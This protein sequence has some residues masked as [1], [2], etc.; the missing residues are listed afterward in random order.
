MSS[1][2]RVRRVG[3]W[4]LALLLLAA[5][6]IAVAPSVLVPVLAGRLSAATGANV[7]VGWMSWNPLA[8]RIV[9]HRIAIA[10]TETAPAVITVQA[11]TV[12]VAL[13]RWLDGERALDALILRRPWVS[14]RRTGPGDFNLASL[15]P[16]LQAAMTAATATTAEDMGPPIPLR[17]GA[18]R[19]VSGSI[20]FHDETTVPVLETSLHL[21]DAT[22]RDLVLATDGSAGLAFHVESRIENEPLTLDVS[23]DT[24]PESSHLTATLVAAEASLARALLYVPLGWQRTSGTLDATV[25]Y[26]RRAEKNVLRHHG[27]KAVLALHDLSLTEP[28]ATEPMLRAALVRVPALAVDFIKQ[29]TDLGSIQVD[30]FQALVVGDAAGVHI[31]LA[32]GSPGTEASSWQTTL[33]SVALGKGTAVLRNIL[34]DSGPE[35]VIPLSGGTIRLPPNEVS[36]SFAGALAGGR[37]TLDGRTRGTASTLSFG[38]E[39]L[40]LTEAPHLFGF[41]LPFAKGR[42]H[43][44]L[45]VQL[46]GTTPILSGTLSSTDT[47][48][49][50]SAEHPE[51]V[52]A[53]QRLELTLAESTLDPFSLHLTDATATW[54]YVMIHR[55]SDGVFPLTLAGTSPSPAAPTSDP[56]WLHLDR[57]TVQGGRVE[58][59]DS[60]LPEPY[61]ID[62]T[63]LVIAADGI[64]LAPLRAQRITLKGALDELSPLEVSGTISP[65]STTLAL[66]VDRLLLPPLNPYLAPALGYEVKTGLARI[67]SD[68]RFNGTTLAADND[69]VLSRFAMRRAGQDTV[70]ATI[71][72]P[73]SVALALM[74]DTR[75][76]IHL[77]LPIEGDLTANQYRV[78]NLLREALGN[79]LL[80]TLRAP[81]GFLRGLFSTDQGEQFDLRPV[82]FPAGSATL[83]P[84]GESRIAE[85]AHLLGR[86]T[87]LRAVLIPEPSRADL[88][89][90][91]TTENPRPLDALADLA[92]TR[93]TLVAERLTKGQGIAAAR[94]SIEAWQPAEPQ[95]EGDPGVDVQLQAE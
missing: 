61:G 92:R 16:T 40:A 24:A 88:E 60:T 19:I 75:G 63:D 74:K 43:G 26:E 89:H 78:G 86:Q 91:R 30:D 44:N 79:A 34:A 3:W 70:E 33:D 27:L 51:E 6:T 68:V 28:W 37:V 87:A 50:P 66:S 77:E 5:A 4:L 22:A 23:Y 54:P 59:Y 69:V 80:G 48:M 67:T 13:R 9:L 52:L 36:F 12:D 93:A 38:L 8:G 39:D 83:G 90:L 85:V 53:W 62:L 72:V 81:L 35:L 14:L 10:P 82:P 84:E 25:T 32:T 15:F 46:G 65:A 45:E 42:L 1:R 21:D 76:D 31:P 56:S 7:R 17:I 64:S 47:S 71:G 95:I 2:P 94:V 29:R 57:V 55:R 20:E 58:Y 11:L 41:P 73:L 18:L 49:A